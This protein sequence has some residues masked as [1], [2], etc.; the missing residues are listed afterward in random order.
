LG[1]LPGAGGTQRLTRIAGEAVARRLIL[2]AEVVT[3]LQAA[4]LGIVQW[5]VPT[6]ALESRART[7]AREIASLP[8]AALAAAK[9]CIA[10]AITPGA[11]G[12][13][14]ELDATGTLLAQEGTQARVRAFLEKAAHSPPAR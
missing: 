5:A 12:C 11:D 8:A 3:G 1:L 4:A 6:V 14:M 9:R 2:S 10:A 13:A 7:L